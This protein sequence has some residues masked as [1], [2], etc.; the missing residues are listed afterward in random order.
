MQIFIKT[1]RSK[2]IALDVSQDDKILLVKQKIQ[3]REGIPAEMLRLIYEGKQM[4][5][6][7]ILSDY[8]VQK[9]STLHIHAPISNMINS[10]TIRPSH[11]DCT[12]KIPL[13]QMTEIHSSMIYGNVDSFQHLLETSKGKIS[14]EN[15]HR[16]NCF[17]SSRP[18][19]PSLLMYMYDCP[20]L[21]VALLTSVPI[22]KFLIQIGADVNAVS[23]SVPD[24]TVTSESI[25]NVHG[26]FQH[27]Y[28]KVTALHMCVHVGDVNLIELLVSKGANVTEE[29]AT[30]N[31]PMDI[32]M[33]RR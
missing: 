8:N 4:K 14:L 1:L 29:D 3:D 30:G 6:D 25:K 21:H 33:A 15:L 16:C 26:Q 32:A 23:G 18:N 10:T 31:T 19:G 22:A 2:I 12:V 9:E 27:F 24:N 17:I 7:L 5:D 20:L 13:E 11:L 28:G